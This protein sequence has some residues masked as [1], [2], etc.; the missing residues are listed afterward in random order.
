MGQLQVLALEWDRSARTQGPAQQVE[1]SKLL[2][3]KK[4]TK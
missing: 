1:G 4:E 3:K 2:I